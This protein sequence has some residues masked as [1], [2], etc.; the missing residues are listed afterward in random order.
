MMPPL[1]TNHLGRLRA[2]G[3]EI[4][5]Q[6]GELLPLARAVAEIFGGELIAFNSFVY[7][8]LDTPFGDITVE[9]DSSVL[10]DERYKRFLKEVGVDADELGVA[11]IVEKTLAKIAGTFVPHE[12]VLPPIP[13]DRLGVIE[14]LESA[15]RRRRVK[16]TKAS[17]LYAF[18]LQINVDIPSSEPRILIDYLKAFLL[19]YDW[20]FKVSQIDLTRR[21]SPY[22]NEFPAVYCR[23]ALDPAYGPDLPNFIDDY[24]KHNPTRNRPLDFLPLFAF[25]DEAR[26]RR[27]PVEQHLVKPRAAFHYRLPNCQIDDPQWSAAVE[28]N[29]WVQVERLA[30][31]PDKIA[32]MS[33]DYL[34]TVSSATNG[35]IDA[36]V[37]K[38]ADWIERS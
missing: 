26:V 20:L 13:L 25:L 9:L 28:W 8:I 3:F 5:M 31:A 29:R 1:R 36:W 19:L 38:T 32:A 17:L 12:I 2:V 10:K 23:R 14:R 4:E 7:K 30:A 18:S 6:G 27:H 22:I 35:N 15:L 34:T 11:G 16:G 21:L 33:R 37:A 24:L